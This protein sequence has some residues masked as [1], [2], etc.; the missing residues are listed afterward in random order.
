MKYY[1]QLGQD[2]L[3]DRLLENKTNGTFVDIGASYFDNMNNS[4]FFEKERGWKGLAVEIDNRYNEGWKNRPNTVYINE[5]ALKVDY[6][7]EM[8]KFGFPDVIDYLSVDLE[9]PEVTYQAFCKVMETKYIF[10][11]ITFEVD[12]YR[13]TSTRDPAR[14]MV[15]DKGY[16]LIAEIKQGDSHIDDVYIHQ[17]LYE[18]IKHKL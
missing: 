2:V 10:S 13:D 14:Q 4:Y 5:D 3:V 8:E 16:Q 7:T 11:V 17:S 1:S 12:Y 9:P 18:K 15:E 6:V